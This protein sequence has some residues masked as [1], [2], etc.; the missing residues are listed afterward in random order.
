MRSTL[1]DEA[2]LNDNKTIIESYIAN[3]S[4]FIESRE[5]EGLSE[6]RSFMKWRQILLITLKIVK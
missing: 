2:I 1:E 4:M 3:K 5:K 6:E